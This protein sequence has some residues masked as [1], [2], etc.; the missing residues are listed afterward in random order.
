MDIAKLPLSPGKKAGDFVYVSGQL[1]FGED[2]SIVD[3][4]VAE[5][6]RQAL[7]NIERIL[8]SH[9]AQLGDV[10]KMNIWLTAKSD[11]LEFNAAYSEHFKPGQFPARSTVVSDLLIEGAK[12][13]IDAIAYLGQ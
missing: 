8:D 3:G 5:Q 1:G 6:A 11:F 12:V 10:I 2:G 4:G 7:R 9:G 13:E